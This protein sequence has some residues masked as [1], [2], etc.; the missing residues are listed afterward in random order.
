MDRKCRKSNHTKR[1]KSKWTAPY[2][3]PCSSILCIYLCHMY[4]PM[5]YVYTYVICIYLCQTK[6]R[7]RFLYH[8]YGIMYDHVYSIMYDHVYSIIWYT[9]WHGMVCI[10]YMYP[11]ILTARP[12]KSLSLVRLSGEGISITQL[13]RH[14]T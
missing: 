12:S 14:V 5:S 13:K 11:N 4:I 9:V 1:N 8:V 10:K 2:M 3:S 6:S 7:H